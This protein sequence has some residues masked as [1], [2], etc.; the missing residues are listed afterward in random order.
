MSR[1]PISSPTRDDSPETLDK[2][3][4]VPT[5][6]IEGVELDDDDEERQDALDAATELLFNTASP[7]VVAAMQRLAGR[8]GLQRMREWG[9]Q[10]QSSLREG[11]SVSRK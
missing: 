10:A 4:A 2:P 6:E 9:L 7:D 1:Q 8:I 3:K 5:I 11:S